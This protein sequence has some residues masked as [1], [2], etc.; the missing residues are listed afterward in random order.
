[1]AVLLFEPYRKGLAKLLAKPLVY[2]ETYLASEGFIA[3]QDKQYSKGMKLV[4]NE[5]I[6]FEFVP[7]DESNFDSE[8]NMVENPEALMLH[9][10]EE[11]KEY[12][13]L[14]STSAG[15]WRYLIGDT[16]AL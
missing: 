16:F 5:H 7:F 14:L 9:E 1:M 6:F 11:G 3:Y 4:T 12:A 2:I 8:G 10:I 15:S 13:I